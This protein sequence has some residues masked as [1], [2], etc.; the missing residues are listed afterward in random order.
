MP[1]CGGPPALLRDSEVLG[2]GLGPH[3]AAWLPHW[4]VAYSAQICPLPKAAP[5]TQ[6]CWWNSARQVVGRNPV[7]HL[8]ESF[9]SHSLVPIPVEAC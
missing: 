1:A 4:V 5:D 3:S 7:A 8:S 9:V 2:L 6:R